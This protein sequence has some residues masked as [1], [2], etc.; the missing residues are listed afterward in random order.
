MYGLKQISRA[1]YTKLRSTLQ[2][3][4]FSKV[5]SNAYLFIKRI[6]A[7]V[8]FLLV[9]VD[10]ILVTSSNPISLKACIQ[11]LDAHFALKTLGS[12]SYFLGFEAYRDA[13][14]MYL[15]QSKYIL[16]LLKNASMQ[17]CK[18]CDI[19]LTFRFSFIDER[20]LFSDPFLYRTIIGSL[21]YL[22]HTRPDIS[23]VVNRLSQFLSSPKMEHWL[24]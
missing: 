20:E 3:W 14:G 24:I 11:D 5:V 13:E 9:Y 7:V 15:T 12:V 4:G 22:I 17:D 1:W 19:P 21:Q 8:F 18:P 16:D 6:D 23:F 2:G 10:D